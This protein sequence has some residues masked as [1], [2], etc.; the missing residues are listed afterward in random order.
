MNGKDSFFLISLGCAKNL[1]DSEHMLGILRSEGFDPAPNLE[2]ADIA[3]INTCGFLQA[4]AEEAIDTILEAAD[5]KKRGDLTRLIVVG[6]FVQR[7]GYKLIKE[8]PE[9][10]GW[11]G[12][13]EIHRI[14]A[15]LRDDNSNIS[16]PFF[17]SRPNYLADHST[18][19]IQTTPF[20]SAF[21]KIAEGCSHTCS[22]CIIPS[23]RGPF[24]SRNTE[25]LLIEAEEMVSRGV[26]EIN[27]IAQ[28]T[29]MFGKDLGKGESLED[30]L[31]KLLT[32]KRIS[33]IRLLYCHPHRIS[34]RL[35]DLMDSEKAICPY[36]DLPLQHINE[37]I[38]HN[39][40]R[41][42]RGE[43]PRQ[44]IERI[45]SGRREISLR[46]TFM[47]GFPGETEEIFNELC[48]FVRFARF[49]HM[50]AFVFS[51]EKGTAAARLGASVEKEEAKHRLEKIVAIQSDISQEKN[52]RMLGRTVP[53]LVEGP[54][55]DT[56]LLLKGR[57]A[58][59]APDVDMQVLINKGNGIVGEIMPVHITE[60]YPYDLIGEIVV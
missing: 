12:T 27:L 53:V 54:S 16:T 3:V 33:W 36:I 31:E 8:I 26:K 44:L 58:T 59:M 7:Y 4:A 32:I 15:V 17:I 18:P 60:V 57:T 38:L 42:S 45:R 2:E 13:G 6:C 20:Y 28:D 52:R 56:D 11:L 23:L 1:V 21:L 29:T 5:L 55:N 19:R 51:S 24:R 49:E 40:R 41:D 43:A 9:V 25:S 35:L 14:A 50:G 10:D 39:M 22:Y 30:L 48:D 37:Q 46:T 34:N 47:L